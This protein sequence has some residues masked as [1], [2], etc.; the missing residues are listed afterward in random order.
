VCACWLS[1]L[2]WSEIKQLWDVGFQEYA[3]DMW[4]VIDFV[5]NSLYVATV[6]LRIVSYYQVSQHSLCLMYLSQRACCVCNLSLF[7]LSTTARARLAFKFLQ[8][9]S[10]G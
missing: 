9:S 3:H 7:L 4:N 6:A 8:K 10:N 5:T 1:G 2:I